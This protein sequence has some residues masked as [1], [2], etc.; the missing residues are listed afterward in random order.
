M[1]ISKWICQS[2]I[3]VILHRIKILY[4]FCFSLHNHLDVAYIMFS[5]FSLHL[6]VCFGLTA[7]GKKAVVANPRACTLCR[8]CIRG[9]NEELV[10]LRRVKDHFICKHCNYFQDYMLLISGLFDLMYLSWLS[11]V[12][13]ES[14]GALSPEELFIEAVKIL[15]DKCD[16]VISELS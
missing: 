8:E 15:E 4:K 14:T 1:D 2:L 9:V 3:S 5:V 12:T 11:A 6:V 13:I 16:R 7:G 10:E